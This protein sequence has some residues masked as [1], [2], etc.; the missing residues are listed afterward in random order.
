M[1]R[2]LFEPLIA[3]YL[4]T[5]KAGGYALIAL[6][7]TIE[8]SVLPLPSELVIPPAAHLSQNG[9]NSPQPRWHCHRRNPRLMA[10]RDDDVLGRKA[11][12]A[13]AIS[14]L[15]KTDL[16]DARENRG[17]TNVGPRSY[18]SMGIFISRLLPSC[19]ISSAYRRASC[20]W[21]TNCF[22]SLRCSV[23]R[24]L[25]RGAMLCRHQDGPGRASHEGQLHRITLWLGG[26]MLVLGGLYYF[27]VHRQMKEREE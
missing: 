5:L 27:M 23:R 10:R 26:A 4:A 8:S 22:R 15:R 24:Y 18:G 1:F 9:A 7:M 3:W 14:E 25:V 16:G 6:L 13:S 17:R 20:G 2:K 21:T 11:C 19:G 12:G